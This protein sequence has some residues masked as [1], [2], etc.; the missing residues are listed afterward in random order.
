MKKLIYLIIFALMASIAYA[1]SYQSNDFVLDYLVPLEGGNASLQDFVFD[2]AIAQPAIGNSSQDAFS[3]CLGVFCTDMLVPIYAINISGQLKYDNGMPIK[4]GIVY[5]TAL[6]AIASTR[7]DNNGM[8][9]VTIMP[10]SENLIWLKN[11]PIYMRVIGDVEA[12]YYCIYDW[13]AQTCS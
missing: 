12:V 3:L 1:N 13:D 11:F 9:N 7:T 6:G 8:F 5:V 10:I 2:V 4:D